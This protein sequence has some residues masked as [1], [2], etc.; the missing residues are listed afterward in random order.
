[1]SHVFPVQLLQQD[2]ISFACFNKRVI[3]PLEFPARV[4]HSAI[5]VKSQGIVGRDFVV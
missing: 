4:S 1:M 2:D 3:D 5:Q